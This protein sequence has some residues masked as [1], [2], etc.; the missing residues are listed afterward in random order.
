M[1]PYKTVKK[2]DVRPLIKQG[3]EPFDVIRKELD[4]LKPGQGLMLLAPFLPSPLIERMH[5][6]GFLSKVERGKGSDWVV[7]FW[8]PEATS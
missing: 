1:A 2:L 8:K 5:S 4:S 3:V 6:E 7:Y